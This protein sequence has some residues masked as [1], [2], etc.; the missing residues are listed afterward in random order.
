MKHTLSVVMLLCG[1]LAAAALPELPLVRTGEAMVLDGKA[2]E[3]AWQKAPWHGGFT[4]LGNTPSPAREQTRFKLLRDGN[5]LWFFWECQDGVVTGE[6]RPLDDAVW[7]DDCVEIFLVTAPE[8]S[9]DRNIREY[10]QIV[11]NPAGAV[12]DMF[13]RGGS[14]DSTWNS[15]AKTAA[16]RV[17]GGWQLELYLPFAAFP[18]AHPGEWRIL[19]GRENRGGE[20]EISSFPPA[21]KFQEEEQYARLK[22]IGLE[23]RRFRNALSSF[24]IATKMAIFLEDYRVTRYA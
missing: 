16:R 19:C 10:Y 5:G 21:L 2:D 18:E 8:I 6:P 20:A 11:V 23:G 14:A 17:K 15:L 4:R 1:A 24:E 12:Y 7:H 3:A 22:G 9:P 13:S